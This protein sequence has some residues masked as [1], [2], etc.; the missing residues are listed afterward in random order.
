M[1][2]NWWPSPLAVS[3]LRE[4]QEELLWEL[5]QQFPAAA[6]D[7]PL[8]RAMLSLGERV[9]ADLKERLGL[10]E[11]RQGAILGWRITSRL[12]GLRFQIDEQSDRTIV[13]HTHCPL[14]DRFRQR[15]ELACPRF[16]ETLARG[17]ARQ[18]APQCRMEVVQ[19]ATLQE[20]CSKALIDPE[21]TP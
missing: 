21:G 1:L 6:D 12:A 4:S 18:V 7:D 2:S 14:W 8:A 16:C 9:G 5:H 13:N 19:A 11:D 3:A 20:P 15:G 10:T 17:I